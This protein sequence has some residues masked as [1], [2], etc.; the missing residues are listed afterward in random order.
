[1]YST[2]TLVESATN[3]LE[4]WIPLYHLVKIAF[5]LWCMLPQTQGALLIYRTVIEP[6]LVRY[7]GRIDNAHHRVQRSVDE[8]AGDFAH[9]GVEALDSKKRE[10][11][12][13]AI[14]SL[15]GAHSAPG[16]ASAPYEHEEHS[17]SL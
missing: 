11:V 14:S 4:T 2:F 7:E 8:V 15:I 10:L 1:V 12:D 16:G 5:L 17:K 3:L 9:A 13:G 6:I